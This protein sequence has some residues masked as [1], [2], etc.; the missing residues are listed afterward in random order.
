MGEVRGE[1]GSRGGARSG[2]G[3][4]P[5]GSEEWSGSISSAVWSVDGGI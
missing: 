3:L 2:G 5:E 4:F 1:W